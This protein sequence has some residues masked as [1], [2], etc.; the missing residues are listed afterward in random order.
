MLLKDKA[1]SVEIYEFRELDT[2]SMKTYPCDREMDINYSHDSL[3]DYNS[4]VEN[5]K[6]GI[7]QFV[8][9]VDNLMI[10][11]TLHIRESL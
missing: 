7:F 3:P 5:K 1:L 8:Q 10:I 4:E 9:L 11:F 2:A 6:E